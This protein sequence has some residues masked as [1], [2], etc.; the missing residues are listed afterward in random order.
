MNLNLIMPMGGSGTRFNSAGYETPKPLIEIYG[1]PFFFWATQ[2]VI[3][4]LPVKTLTFVVLKDHIKT[5]HIDRIISELYPDSQIT[6]IPEVLPG[7]VMTC[8]EGVKNLPEDQPVLF[9][10][11]DHLF[12]CPTFYDFERK[13]EE[14][15]LLQDVREKNSKTG[16]LLN[17]IRDDRKID[18]GLLTFKSTD[19]RFSYV[20]FN[21][22][23]K[24]IGTAEKEVISNE[25]ICGAY[26]FRSRKLFEN[27]A[28][29]YLQKC[30]YT[31]FFISGMYNVLCEH[32]ANICTFPVDHHVS[33]GT[34]EEYFLAQEDKAY[35]KLIPG[36][37]A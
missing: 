1:K 16:S 6:V 35:Q 15:I 7:A 18:A 5:Y 23:G 29:E 2:S 24:V 21:A 36:S 12:L 37:D 25:A 28:G 8:L 4:F 14:S 17:C 20:R 32:N 22:E 9:N 19:A 33:F 3:K 26:Y 10:D 30:N 34:P 31:E 13:N 11:C 27:A